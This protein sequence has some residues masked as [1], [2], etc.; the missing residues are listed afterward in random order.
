MFVFGFAIVAFLKKIL[1][2]F[3]EEQN[4][5]E[6]GNQN[7]KENNEMFEL[8]GEN[9]NNVMILEKTKRKYGNKITSLTNVL[10]V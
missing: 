3:L 6:K 9:E 5:K 8:S 2:L 4:R 10:L 1:M 7:E